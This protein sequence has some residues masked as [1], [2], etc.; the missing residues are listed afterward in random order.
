MRT[1]VL[2]ATVIG[3]CVYA[4]DERPNVVLFMPD[5]MGFLWSES[6]DDPAGGTEFDPTYVPNMNRIRDE[7]VIFTSAYTAGPKCSPARFNLLTGRYCSRSQHARDGSIGDRTNVGVPSCKIEGSDI[8]QTIQKQMQ[9]AGYTTIHSG[10][11]HLLPEG[12]GIN[13]WSDYNAAWRG[14]HDTG[15]EE[16]GGMYCTNMGDPTLSFSH[17][18]DWMT[19]LSENAME[20]AVGAGQPFFLYF[21]STMPHGPNG[22]HALTNFADT[23]TPNGT[24]SASPVSG[25]PSR[26]QILNEGLRQSKLVGVIATDYALGALVS[27]LESLQVL[28]STIII[29]LMDH[30]T[31]AKDHLYE[32]GTRIMMAARYPPHIAAHSTVSAPVANLDIVPT[33]LEAAGISAAYALD[34]QSWWSLVGSAGVG[35]ST[36]DF[37][38]SEIDTDRSIVTASGYKYIQSQSGGT[39]NEYPASGQTHQF[40]D[41]ALDP[42][43]QN[44]VIDDPTYAA[45]VA[46]LQALLT[47]HDAST[48]RENP[49]GEACTLTG[50]GAPTTPP[51]APPTTLSPTSARAMGGMGSMAG[52]MG[53]GR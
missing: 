10:K 2:W 32:G 33:V 35:A 15:F 7:G 40:Y 17:N 52:M 42:T 22:V 47:C 31:I 38:I 48:H 37:V 53:M 51:T 13:C 1:I 29:V 19:S 4:D 41:L 8:S 36:R 28:D 49:T 20:T 23:N 21:A 39:L 34:G 5:D 14:A 30:G 46:A 50:S 9:D 6:P 3:T 44:N 43:E 11:F 25:M 27:K 45:T 26:Q 24:L 12:A 16:D 18:L